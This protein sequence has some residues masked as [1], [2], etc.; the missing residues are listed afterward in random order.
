MNAGE[1]IISGGG[2]NSL[3]GEGALAE[4]ERTLLCA[5]ASDWNLCSTA[6]LPL[7]IIFPHPRV[8]RLASLDHAMWFHRPV[9]LDEWVCPHIVPTAL[10]SAREHL[11]DICTKLMQ[12]AAEHAAPA[13]TAHT[14]L[15]LPQ[16]G[17]E[18]ETLYMVAS[19]QHYNGG[20]CFDCPPRPPP[21]AHH[22]LAPH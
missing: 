16:K 17:D 15:R 14:N 1:N 19:G 3:G 13:P 5:F 6:M 18:P 20:C 12:A 22:A 11:A 8:K 2:S 4:H 21:P 10:G 7:G 9:P